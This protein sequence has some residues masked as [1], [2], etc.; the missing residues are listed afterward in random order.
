MKRI[1]IF[2]ALFLIF[3]IIRLNA[4]TRVAN[5]ATEL[6][7][8]SSVVSPGDTILLRDGVWLNQE[9]QFKGNG[10]QGDSIVI[11]PETPGHVIFTGNSKF[12]FGG[13]YIKID[14]LRF[15]AGYTTDGHVIEFRNGSES[16][17]CRVTNT[18]I[19][20]YNPATPRDEYKYLSI[21]GKNNRVDHCYFTGKTNSGATLVVWPKTD[22]QVYHQIDHNYFGHRPAL[23]E[24]G[25]ETIR[26]GT[27]DVSMSDAGCIVEY[28]YFE[29]C[30]GEIE[31]ISNKTGNN[32][33]RY[34]TF[35]KCN[36]ML[37]LRH[38]N[39]SRV[40]GN[41]FIGEGKSGSGGVRI[42]GE[43]HV[44]INNYFEG[45]TG[46]SVDWRSP[47]TFMNG[48]PNSPLNR[49]FQVKNATVA[50]N[51]IVNCV[52]NIAIGTGVSTELSLP[53]AQ[54]TI[55]N[56]V[57]KSDNQLINIYDTPEEFKWEGNYFS[58]SSLGMESIV[59]IS[60]EDPLLELSADNLFR[61]SSVSPV[62]GASVGDYPEIIDDMDGQSR[63]ILK[64]AGADQVSDETV[65]RGP[66]SAEDVGPSWLNEA[67]PVGLFIENNGRGEV[68]TDPIGTIFEPGT[69]V[70]LT[71]VPQ[72]GSTF[73]GWT[74]DVV[75]NENPITVVMDSHMS[76]TANYSDPNLYKLSFWVLGSGN[77]EVDPLMNEYPEG[78][79]VTIT[80]VP[81]AGWAFSSWGGSLSGTKNPITLVMDG[82]KVVSP[83]FIEVTAVEE[84]EIDNTFSLSQ[85]YP[86]PFNPTTSISFSLEKE[87]Y[88]TLLI[89]NSLGQKIKDICS[90]FYSAGSY[91]FQFDASGLPSGTYYYQL[92]SSSGNLINKMTLVK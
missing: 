52:S 77:V 2:A 43:D 47:I 78:T 48:V 73:E 81:E 10:A 24:N 25:G 28:N 34:N 11:M 56:N 45:L 16:N 3:I 15:I 26:I 36:G 9:V 4:T 59:G 49:Y 40:E 53:P 19:V 92:A 50:F 38:G 80:A 20:N 90:G 67:L 85:N 32:T 23:G 72:S 69:E 51:T 30:D 35:Y 65:N 7:S 46:N 17:Y 42:I 79:T 33:F 37:T 22:Q 41:Y 55:A 83:T 5:N 62:I 66:L 84:N 82:N 89:Y 61:P 18:S 8:F 1:L 71:A 6:N 27:S 86:N 75:S 12:R 58:G 57:I 88:I 91:S 14:G 68:T 21:Y 54:S 31:I 87:D 74:G 64:D 60:E 39:G 76:I 44:V 29:E 70:S 63:G 13:T